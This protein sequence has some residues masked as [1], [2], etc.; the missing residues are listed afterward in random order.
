MPSTKTPAAPRRS[1]TPEPRAAHASPAVTSAP[2]GWQPSGLVGVTTADGPM[3]V[4]G[5]VDAHEL[6]RDVLDECRGEIAGK[7]LDVSVRLLARGYRINADAERLR[8]VF[9]H[10]VKTAVAATPFRGRLTFRSTCPGDSAL[11]LEVEERS[12]WLRRSH[13]PGTAKPN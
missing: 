4:V 8:R 5:E 13:R 3:P 12:P 1:P 9:H 2:G 7:K 6:L 10:M 11:R